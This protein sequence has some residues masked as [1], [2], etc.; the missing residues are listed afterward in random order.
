MR[1]RRPASRPRSCSAWLASFALLGL[2]P[3]SARACGPIPEP[4]A[5]TL[6]LDPA[7]LGDDAPL[8]W[9]PQTFWEPVDWSAIRATDARS[10][11]SW[12]GSNAPADS[13]ISWLESDQEDS[14]ARTLRSAD[15]RKRLSGAL[16]YWRTA[17]RDPLP[18]DEDGA[19]PQG[20]DDGWTDTLLRSYRAEKE[21]FLRQRWAYQALRW[22]SFRQWGA[23]RS[24]WGKQEERLL[25]AVH[26]GPDRGFRLRADALLGRN[27]RE[28]FDGLPA[29]KTTVVYDF[30]PET[31]EEWQE[32]LAAASPEERVF[33]WLLT[34]LRSGDDV[35]ALRQ[36]LSIDPGSRRTAP[37]L[38]RALQ[39][40]EPPARDWVAEDPD[41]S[42]LA[43]LARGA[44][45]RPSTPHRW[46]W[47]LA[48]ARLAADSE[49]GL[50]R[51]LAAR[52]EKEMTPAAAAQ[53]DAEEA[54]LRARLVRSATDSN[55][56]RLGALLALP[57]LR[58]VRMTRGEDEWILKEFPAR[59]GDRIAS[60]LA[61]A[62]YDDTLLSAAL[63]NRAPADPDLIGRLSARMTTN[64]DPLVSWAWDRSGRHQ[65]FWS[66][67]LSDAWFRTGRFGQARAAGERFR[68][69]DSLDL[70]NDPFVVPWP[71]TREGVP[72]SGSLTRR[73]LLDSLAGLESL[74]AR[75]GSA[76]ARAAYLLAAA[77]HRL[78]DFGDDPDFIRYVETATDTALLAF[79]LGQA[80]RAERDLPGKEDRA[81][82]AVLAARL[83]R[84]LQMARGGCRVSE[85]TWSSWENCPEVVP[86]ARTAFA[87]IL[88]RHEKTRVGKRFLQECSIYAGW[89]EESA[90]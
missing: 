33:L 38:F 55:A 37:L 60:D 50:H 62:P 88:S 81:L 9:D 53:L 5:W 87:R 13:V 64:A 90:P 84:D 83:E 49:S 31:D 16:R 89:R 77:A 76:G 71:E 8:A 34:G 28:V 3:E 12:L 26:D 2:L 58:N 39:K 7:V 1:S 72:V 80:L 70:T 42:A 40:R 51:I 46:L 47:H 22:G 6:L 65:D 48:L 15:G 32:R 56:L 69:W 79:G 27:P 59:W 29:W 19:P 14:L 24:D 75:K 36:I 54:S 25:Q 74:A 68:A 82:A 20:P 85:G 44:L 41:D 23:R 30:H 45:A 21:P 17:N 11:T 78:T 61:M 86:A 35:E 52:T 18:T 66:A 63:R 73:K 57:S 43:S 4:V 67:A 10:W